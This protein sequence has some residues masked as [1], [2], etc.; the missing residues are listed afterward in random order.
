MSAVIDRSA[1]RLR[2]LEGLFLICHVVIFFLP[3]LSI[4]QEN[5]PEQ[6]FSQFSFFHD[7]FLSGSGAAQASVSGNMR[8]LTVLCILIPMLLAMFF[9]IGSFIDKIPDKYIAIGGI[10]AGVLSLMHLLLARGIWPKR[11][12]DAQSYDRRI[13]WWLLAIVVLGMLFSAILLLAASIQKVAEKK[14]ML[15]SE[16]GKDE[17]DMSIAPRNDAKEITRGIYGVDHVRNQDFSHNHFME[18]DEDSMVSHTQTQTEIQV[19][20]MLSAKQIVQQSRTGVTDHPRGVM[21]GIAG[22][23]RGAEITMQDGE[24]MHLG[25]DL[26]ND[27]VFQDAAH[28]SRMH[29]NII[30]QAEQQNYLIEDHSSNG[31]YINN[32]SERLSKNVQ[33]ALEPGTIIDIGD[34]TNRFRLE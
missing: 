14:E 19:S 3:E 22:V 2:M 4:W 15:L 5:Y 31:C 34:R 10:A 27:L 30:W 6:T 13:G 12:N 8:L 18:A 23:F 20:S 1:D 9:G 25:R 29:C 21:V 26:S 28:I 7:Y 17:A 11:L 33:I 16:Q 24:I 32:A